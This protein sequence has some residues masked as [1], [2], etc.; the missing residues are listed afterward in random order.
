MGI[1]VVWFVL[2]LIIGGAASDRGRSGVNWFFI[3]ILTT[4]VLALLLLI[5]SGDKRQRA[6]A[7]AWL[8]R[9]PSENDGNLQSWRQ[10]ELAPAQTNRGRAIIV[11]DGAFRFP[12]V[13]ESHYQR[14]IESVTGKRTEEGLHGFRIGAVLVPEPTNP[15]DPNAVAVHIEG[16]V[17]GY[18]ARDVA[19]TFKKAL[20]DG[21]FDS[22]ETQAAIRGGW[23]RGG[24][25]K[26]DFG[27]WLDAR[28]PF[29]LKA[30]ASPAA[31]LAPPPREIA[32]I[33][34]PEPSV[35]RRFLPSVVALGIILAFAGFLAVVRTHSDSQETGSSGAGGVTTVVQGIGGGAE[36]VPTV[37]TPSNIPPP[38][39]S[40]PKLPTPKAKPKIAAP[41]NLRPQKP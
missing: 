13:G 16:L 14:E 6:A 28:L 32:D 20:T 26:G 12:I 34:L 9:P 2:A 22:A 1:I 11:S 38:S 8:A 7:P 41:M 29:V 25:D 24:G 23:N 5:A 18:L 19:P 33:P 21:C 30:A 31:S 40:P 3:A 10:F 15:Y 4:P 17:V 35:F 39:I 27:V 36:V 37:S